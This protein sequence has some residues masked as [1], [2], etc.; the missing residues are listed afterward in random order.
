MTLLIG[1]TCTKLCDKISPANTSAAPCVKEEG[2]VGEGREEVREGRKEGGRVCVCV[3]HDA[4]MTVFRE[5]V[6]MP[7]REKR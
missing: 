7:Q 5:T 1:H 2:K 4:K 3:C 6:C